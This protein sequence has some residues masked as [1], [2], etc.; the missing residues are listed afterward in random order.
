MSRPNSGPLPFDVEL[1]VP[2][3]SVDVAARFEVEAMDGSA[4]M[5]PVGWVIELFKRAVAAAMFSGG[6]AAGLD[7]TSASG[8]RAGALEQQWRLCGVDAGA[9]RVLLNLLDV[10]H[11]NL[12]SLRAVRLRDDSR[13]PNSLGRREIYE[14]SYP[15]WS[16][17]VPFE[18]SLKQ[19]LIGAKDV[20]VRIEFARPLDDEEFSRAEAVFVTWTHLITHGGYQNQCGEIELDDAIVCSQTYMAT[21]DTVEHEFVRAVGEMAAFEALLNLA[22]GL[23]RTLVPVTRFEI[24]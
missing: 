16:R 2:G 10:V 14:L 5:A 17:P 22:V 3:A 8:V 24:T 4:S 18:L 15:R 11:A 6:R 19:R 20:L 21:P 9:Y 1:P 12:T 23:H 13:P 7:V